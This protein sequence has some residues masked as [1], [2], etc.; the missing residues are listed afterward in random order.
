V[1]ARTRA[2]AAVLLPLCCVRF[3]S[4]H[5]YFDGAIC[6][7]RIVHSAVR[8]YSQ[9]IVR[10]LNTLTASACRKVG[11]DPRPYLM[12]CAVRTVWADH[13]YAVACAGAAVSGA[14]LLRYLKR[15]LIPSLHQIS[16]TVLMVRTVVE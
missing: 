10:V 6:S 14:N 12:Y 8:E 4:F 9:G 1:R 13:Q 16:P 15:P 3:V 7:R 5:A 2:A 11:T